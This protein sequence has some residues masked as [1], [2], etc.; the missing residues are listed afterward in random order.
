LL[1][2]VENTMLSDM[3]PAK[4]P[5]LDAFYAAISRRLRGHSVPCAI[6][7]GLACVEFGVAELARNL[8][9]IS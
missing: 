8:T 1:V 9:H 6:T 3:R 2:L 7:G 4:L 5:S